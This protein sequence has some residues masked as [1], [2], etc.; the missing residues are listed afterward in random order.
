MEKKG[1]K[2]MTVRGA[3]K[4]VDGLN[5]G[6]D[7]DAMHQCEELQQYRQYRKLLD[8]VEESHRKDTKRMYVFF[9][10]VFVAFVAVVGASLVFI[11]SGF[12]SELRSGNSSSTKNTDYLE[13]ALPVLIVLVAAFVAFL[14]MNRLKDM[15]TQVDQMRSSI[16]AEL[17]KE[18]SRVT[19]LRED[20]KK[21]VSNEVGSKTQGFVK[22]IKKDLQQASQEAGKYVN[23]NRDQAISDIDVRIK[24]FEASTE[25]ACAS[26]DSFDKRYSWLLSS[27]KEAA[28]D[29]LLR[30]VATVYDVHV[31]VEA[32]W[33]SDQKPNNVAELTRRYV[34]KVTDSES[35][36]RG[37]VNDYHNLA[38]E[39]ARHY[40][41]A[42][43]CNVC[44]AGLDSFPKSID[45]LADWVQYGTSVGDMD[46][47]QAEPL[48][49]LLTIDK[50]QWN[51]RAFDFTIDFYLAAEMF[52]EAE[53]LANA[54]TRHMPY[55]DRAYYCQAEVYQKRYAGEDATQKTIEA[56]KRAVDADI[57][58]PM[59][60][61]KL[62]EILCD[63]G[64]LDEALAAANRAIREL[65]QEQPSVNYG[66]VVYRRGLIL[67]RMAY[68]L[69][70]EGS[71]AHGIAVRSAIDYKVAITSDRLSAITRQQASVRLK[72]LRTYFSIDEHE[73]GDVSSEESTALNLAS[74]M[75]FLQEST[76]ETSDSPGL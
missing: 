16:D 72:L 43:A 55:E 27:N 17:S 70:F 21:Q 14:G 50:D 75:N 57:N 46:A 9:I 36:L 69:E 56:L 54:F 7:V 71:P 42:L 66:Y 3:E 63:C 41:Y 24:D 76:G 47:V 8:V 39:C 23:E 64:R 15:D 30:D 1:E 34:S 22:S 44:K 18:I 25:R 49:V 59:C 4:M 19:A 51:W 6:K 13:L 11:D 33:N 68:K 74:L 53:E 5:V 73:L 31:A 60:A 10:L 32:M 28:Q 12:V 35:A 67:D 61:N 52:E 2:E 48:A 26:L 40:L 58:C 65:S 37:D 45:L 38:A 62:A 20:L 29:A